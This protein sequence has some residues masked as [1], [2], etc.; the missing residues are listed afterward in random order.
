MTHGD[1]APSSVNRYLLP[2]EHQVIMVRRHPA[3]LLRPV[4]EVFGG[5]IIAGLLSKFF[6]DKGGGTA[7][8]VVWWLWLLLL[9]RFVWKVAE[10]SVD[11]FVVTS[12]RMLLTTGL[13]TRK[14]AMMPLQK[15]TDMSFQ[16]SLLGR[17]LGYGEF[18]LESAGQDQA[19]SNV[20]Y[21]PYPETLYLEVCQMLFPSKDDGDD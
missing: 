3:V 15:V 12:K 19:L 20:E 21:I 13:I 7:L 8:V 6:G 10:W 14:V 1:S 2:H 5:L 18:I 17:M 4:A 11:Y 16:R 9:I